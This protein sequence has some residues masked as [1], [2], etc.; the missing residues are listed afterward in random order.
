M[1]TKLNP[2]IITLLLLSYHS[3][4]AAQIV[5]DA[6]LPSNSRIIT[7]GNTL[8]IEGGSTAGSNLFHSFQEF[9]L[10]TGQEVFFNNNIDIQNIFSRVTGSNISN[11]DGLIRA[12]GS[13]NL[14]LINPNG[15]IFGPNAQLNIGGSFIG[16]TASSIRFIDNSEFSANNPTA[17]PL[18]N[19]NVPI[20]LQ[21]GTN[22]KSI[23]NRSQ[24]TSLIPL[25]PVDPR[26]P[27]PTNVGLQVLPGRILALVGGDVIL[28]NGNLTALQGEIH[29]G[30]IAN[31]GLVRFQPTATGIA[32]DYTG[33]ANFGKIELSGTASVNTSGLGGGA[34]EVRGENLTLRDR[35]NLV[36]NTLG[37]LNGRDI[38]IDVAQFKLAD[39]A[40]VAIDTL[41]KGA[42]GN[43]AI[44]ASD[45]IQLSGIGFD[46]FRRLFIDAAL[47]GTLNP[48]SR[49]SG[50]FTGTIGAGRSG[51]I[52]I[53]TR[54]LTLRDG[55]VIL[56]PTFG[57]GSGGNIAIRATEKIDVSGSGLFT[58]ALNRGNAG[59]LTIDT[60]NLI[61]R[62][63]TTISTATFGA[64][65]GGDLIVKASD[66][67]VLLEGKQESN[68]GTNLSANTV[69]GT[70]NAGNLEIYTRTLR[71]EAGAT[72]T[73][74]SGTTVL[75]RIIPS[76]GRGGN[77]IVNASESVTVTG[78]SQADRPTRSQIVTATLGNADAGNLTINT[79]RLVVEDGG[80]L[81]ASTLGAGNGGNIDIKATDSVEVIGSTRNGQFASGIA[82]ASGDPLLAAFYPI[83]PT[84]AAGNL[85]ITTGRLILKNT[86]TVNVT[87]FGTGRSGTIDVVANGI[88]LDTGGNI[89]ATTGSGAGGNINLQTG[90]IQ[91]R[92]NSRIRTDAGSSNGGNITI[93]TNTLLALE[94]SDITANAARGAGGRV[95]ITT[96]GIFGTQFRDSVTPQSDITAT[97]N[98]G[99]QFNGTVQINTPDINPV[100]GLVELPQTFSDISDPIASSCNASRGNSFTL[101]GLGGLPR[102]P[103]DALNGW[104]NTARFSGVGRGEQES[105]SVILPATNHPSPNA[106]YESA[107]IE[108]TGW[109]VDR[110]GELK[111]VA[112]SDNHISP[113]TWNRETKC[114]L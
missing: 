56:S 12:N 52:T 41:G 30:S 14:F 8:R 43:L 99:L 45:A 38:T 27:I 86:G 71:V 94:N 54:Q 23:T 2:I 85:S 83:N 108:A 11:I 72:I 104:Y 65:A 68:L 33:V 79:N 80:G 60:G 1:T 106:N 89:D 7:E 87:S 59:T 95:S 64:G 74:A 92:R 58:S 44:R 50:L 19:I 32:F 6:T 93:D 98:L 111:L 69:A 101:I 29:L 49:E 105:S 25:P 78:M 26:I 103:Y 3:S 88:Y 63:E 46:N 21:F 67:I 84:G 34:I 51:N 112:N 47:N 66:S 9:S 4:V 91:L 40:F 109:Q 17:P 13:A 10:P 110:N 5:P 22:P 100:A 57:V 42:G 102:N 36:S 107:T 37:N 97:S 70:G 62:D 24:S 73:S 75:G 55:A 28:N 76:G 15:I 31:P 81:G 16:S 77:L 61:L 82:T 96:Q 39:Q 90:D 48:L 20:G 18:L 113:N 35:A 53:D 114:D